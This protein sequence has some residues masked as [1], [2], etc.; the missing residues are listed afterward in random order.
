M[1]SNSVS[2]S[3]RGR[4][5]GGS[6][7]AAHPTCMCALGPSTARNDASSADSRSGG[8][9]SLL[10]RWFRPQSLRSR[11]PSSRTR[12]LTDPS[13]SNPPLRGFIHDLEVGAAD[14]PELVERI[15]VPAPVRRPADVPVR[16]VVGHEHPVLLERT[17]DDAGL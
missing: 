12:L 13:L 16:A 14:A 2:K 17:G 7:V 3:G 4:S 11:D 10:T 5:A 8:I 9:G 1:C 6:N 15:V